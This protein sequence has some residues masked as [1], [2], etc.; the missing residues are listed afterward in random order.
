MQITYES[1]YHIVCEC[2]WVFDT[3]NAMTEDAALLVAL[4]HA[5]EQHEESSEIEDIP[6]FENEMF[7][8]AREIP[9]Y[10][11]LDI[12]IEAL[13]AATANTTETYAPRVAIGWAKQYEH[14]IRTGE[15]PPSQ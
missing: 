7:G 2:G 14:Y 15:S 9:L 11:D 12:R 1:P 5:S 3:S 8:E 6:A 4:K 10:S 13:R